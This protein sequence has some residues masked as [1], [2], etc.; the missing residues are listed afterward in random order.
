MRIAKLVRTLVL[1]AILPL[2]LPYGCSLQ[3]EPVVVD[4]SFWG[5]FRVKLEMKLMDKSGLQDTYGKI[6]RNCVQNLLEMKEYD[7]TKP[8][9]KQFVEDQCGCLYK[10]I[11]QDEHIRDLIEKK[12]TLE[13]LATKAWKF[14]TA[15]YNDTY[16][17]ISQEIE[18]GTIEKSEKC[19]EATMNNWLFSTS[20]QPGIIMLNDE[21]WQ[22]PFIE[23]EL[24][25]TYSD[26]E[27]EDDRISMTNQCIDEARSELRRLGTVNKFSIQ[28][29]TAF[30]KCSI[31]NTVRSPEYRLAKR[32]YDVIEYYESQGYDIDEASYRTESIKMRM[33]V[34]KAGK[35][36]DLECQ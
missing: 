1:M 32:K 35:R 2:L 23:K 28:Y 21:F 24:K 5:S 4:D 25:D 9:H 36:A 31:N 33:D 14:D 8:K 19:M 20:N 3:N 30:C 18:Y 7:L 15:S 17:K 13:N 11:K 12:L 34:D 26:D 22:I 16:G 10:E 27:F 29:A 6:S